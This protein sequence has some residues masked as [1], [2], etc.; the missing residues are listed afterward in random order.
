MP[1]RLG[2]TMIDYSREKSGFSLATGEVTAVSLP[3]LLTEVGALRT[4]IEGITLGNV[5]KESLNVFDT[6]LTNAPPA[7]ALAQVESAWLVLY[8][9]ILPFFDDPVN[10]IPNEGFGRQFT[11]AIPTAEIAT[12][13]R[14]QANSDLANLAEAGMAA[15]V[16]AFEETARSPYGG[17][18][19]IVEIRH[20]GRNR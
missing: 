19:N 10:A 8:E 7:S 12:A 5:H 15:F 9:D 14:L 2:F 6:V 20:V 13:T 18:V 3:D 11:M 4:A 16:T 1:G 17:T